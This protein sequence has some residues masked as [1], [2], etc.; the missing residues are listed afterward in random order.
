VHSTRS[1][2]GL[3][4]K[5]TEDRDPGSSPISSAEIQTITSALLALTIVS[6]KI[7][8]ECFE[9]EPPSDSYARGI[10]YS[11][12]VDSGEKRVLDAYLYVQ[13]SN[14][15]GFD[16]VRALVALLR[17]NEVR[18]T[19]LATL[20][21]SALEAFSRSWFLLSAEGPGAL[22]HRV[23]SLLY[24]ELK[25]PAMNEFTLHTNDGN[26]VDPKVQR[27][28]FQNELK[29]LSLPPALKLNSPNLYPIC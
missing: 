23:L 10:F 7:T 29:R 17:A 6:E 21:R 9:G 5:G 24:A 19:A 20:T 13:Y 4:F 2:N 27:I 25:Y 1:P 18:T 26:A 11:Y 12:D 16:H 28:H 8:A 14:L 15:N 3:A 22:S